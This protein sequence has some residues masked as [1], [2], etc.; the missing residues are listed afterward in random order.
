MK[1]KPIGF[2]AQLA[3]SESPND[4]GKY[5]AINDRIQL[6]DTEYV[7]LQGVIDL[8]TIPVKYYPIVKQGWFK[9]QYD[10]PRE[11]KVI[12]MKRKINHQ[13]MWTFICNSK[14][15]FLAIANEFEIAYTLEAIFN[16]D[17]DIDETGEDVKPQDCPGVAKPSAKDLVYETKVAG[18]NQQYFYGSK[19]SYDAHYA[20]LK[21]LSEEGKKARAENANKTLKTRNWKYII[22]GCKLDIP[23][24]REDFHPITERC[25]ICEN[26]KF[27]HVN[28]FISCFLPYNKNMKIVWEIKQLR[29]EYG[30]DLEKK[31]E[32]LE[33]YRQLVSTGD[34]FEQVQKTRQEID[35]WMERMELIEEGTAD[36]GLLDEY[37][38]L[39]RGKMKILDNKICEEFEKCDF[40]PKFEK[41]NKVR[42]LI[43]LI[44]FK[45]DNYDTMKNMYKDFRTKEKRFR[46]M[47]DNSIES[48]GDFQTSQYF[49]FYHFGK[50]LIGNCLGEIE[51][52]HKNISK[53][54]LDCAMMYFYDT[55][56]AQEAYKLKKYH[57]D[58]RKGAAGE[59]KV[60]HELKLLE[61]SGNYRSVHKKWSVKCLDRT[62]KLYNPDFLNEPMEYDH[63]LVGKQGVFVIETKNYKGKIVVDENGN[64]I[65][66]KTGERDEG[67]DNPMK[68]IYSHVALL[69]SFL[70]GFPIIGVICI[71]HRSAII[72]GVNNCP[73]LLVKS[74]VLYGEIM[75]YSSEG[76]ELTKAEM[77]ECI[78]LIESHRY[79]E[80]S[81]MLNWDLVL[82]DMK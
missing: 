37:L 34:Y 35:H 65:R 33:E 43:W 77:E 41:E 56:T 32:V 61:A 51:N 68:Q 69:E 31:E 40:D 67:E 1:L 82:K 9:D 10:K 22:T 45:R 18:D 21:Y 46:E 20:F 75:D 2:G 72:E 12:A 42:I 79:Q 39:L 19:L 3:V 71:A 27:E 17:D 8:Y 76:K 58:R 52:N 74:D 7:N 57:G 70:K 53:K 6:S 11:L 60:D 49:E 81:D 63:I 16:G 29:S 15:L 78:S 73:V 54:D 48:I 38:L 47:L 14:E 36:K 24:D 5:D 23:N 25:L 30:K 62:I 28:D 26:W 44:N 13:E 59:R 64:W 4:N 80:E 66:N 50:I 55:D